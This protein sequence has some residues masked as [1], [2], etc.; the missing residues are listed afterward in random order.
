MLLKPR[1]DPIGYLKDHLRE[2][3]EIEDVRNITPKSPKMLR[4]PATAA[5]TRS[6]K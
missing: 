4:R 5:E 2:E 1:K 3:Y 6:D